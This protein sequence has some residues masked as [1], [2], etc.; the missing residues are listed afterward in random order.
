MTNKEIRNAVG[1]PALYEG[2][3]EEAVELAHAALKMARIMRGENPTPADLG[4][5]LAKLKEELGDLEIYLD[6]LE[7]WSDNLRYYGKRERME[8]RIQEARDEMP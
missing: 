6:I 2:L 1:M 3:A 8:A 4:D 7:L 5:A